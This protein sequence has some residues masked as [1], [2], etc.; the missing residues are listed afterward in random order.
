MN[1]DGDGV[2]WYAI[3]NYPTDIIETVF[4]PV[5]N[6][7]ININY[8]ATLT[9]WHQSYRGRQVSLAPDGIF[10]FIFTC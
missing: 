2:W 5:S 7:T 6:Y 3:V 8:T 4:V 10:V 1:I 9:P